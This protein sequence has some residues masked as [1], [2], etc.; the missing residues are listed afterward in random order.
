MKIGYKI[1]PGDKVMKKA[2]PI[3]AI[4]LSSLAPSFIYA[5]QFPSA[6]KVNA[7]SA[8][9]R[10]MTI[11]APSSQ[12][13]A[14]KTEVSSEQLNIATEEEATDLS[15]PGEPTFDVPITLNE[16]VEAYIHFFTNRIR[17]KFS[18][19][20][21]RSEKYL[22]MMK[23]TFKEKGL[24]E[25]LTYIA[26]IESGFNDKAYSRAKAV[27]Q[28][29]FIKGTGKRYGLRIDNWVDERRDPEKATEAAA[30][31]FTDLHEMFNDWYL[32]AAG[33]NAGEGK[34]MRAIDKYDTNDFWQLSDPSRRYLKSETKDYVP[35]FIAAALIAKDP[36]KYG[37]DDIDY[38]ETLAYE[39]VAINRVMDLRDIAAVMA[40]DIDDLKSLN[41]ELKTNITPPDYPNYQL[42][43]PVGKK[44]VLESHIADVPLVSEREIMKEARISARKDRSKEKVVS[45]K[46][47][48]IRYVVKRGETIDDIADKYNVRKSHLVKWNKLKGQRL[49]AGKKLMI[50]VSN[51]AN[52]KLS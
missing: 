29:Q 33:Y 22:P 5:D 37:F 45:G 42:R 48:I 15:D 30:D 34:I 40:C 26:L 1:M 4:T 14:T 44:A 18:T 24:P 28:W 51:P 23:K 3:L 11:I 2:L 13:L 10:Q 50:Y 12:S 16:K 25:D 19:W 7:L 38:H 17:G 49:K 52:K 27:G 39:K 46:R 6:D 31:Y 8:D 36:A 35:K 32:A 47:V 43:V 41:P 9:E 20:L 21:A